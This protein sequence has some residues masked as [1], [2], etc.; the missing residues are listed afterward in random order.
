MQSNDP[1]ILDAGQ[2]TPREREVL[3]LAQSGMTNSRIAA[4][5]GI[6]RNAVR[7]HLKDIH[8]KLETGSKRSVLSRGW[9]RGLALFGLPIAK[10]GVPVSVVAFA[11]GMA[12]TGFAAYRALPGEDVRA[13]PRRFDGTVLV[14]G[15]YA[16]GCPAEFNAGTMTLADF[17]NGG[18]TL[19]ELQALNPNVPLGPLAPETMVRVPYNPNNT[20]GQVQPSP[21]ASPTVTATLFI[22]G[23]PAGG[24]VVSQADTRTSGPADTRG[25]CAIV[26]FTSRAPDARWYRMTF[27]GT[28]VTSRLTW[29]RQP[30]MTGG[31]GCYA[32]AEG[33]EPGEHAVEIILANPAW[34]GGMLKAVWNFTV[35]P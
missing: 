16:N 9:T 5:L 15:K 7:F 29:V 20:C 2:L 26:S 28:D 4:E 1:E 18:T 27:D 6:S 35:L 12:V 33:F 30:D 22:T 14:D 34:D 11:A 31:E 8:S 21:T 17:A 23:R 19:E 13:A 25:V 32:P 24:A 10:L 3:A